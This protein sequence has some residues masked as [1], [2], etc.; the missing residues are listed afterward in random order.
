M[1]SSHHLLPPQ[2][3][4]GERQGSG[5]CWTSLLPSQWRET[6]GRREPPW[7]KSVKKSKGH[8]EPELFSSVLCNQ[9]CVG[10]SLKQYWLDE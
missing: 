2:V 3:Q 8:S 7:H 1:T 9:L 10:R 4:S 5:T 6:V